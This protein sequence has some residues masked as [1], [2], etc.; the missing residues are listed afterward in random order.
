M[1]RS[2]M[3]ARIITALIGVIVTPIALGLISAGGIRVY[4]LFSAY[5]YADVD[6]FEFVGPIALNSSVS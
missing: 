1:Q 3:T 4:Q 2:S 6:L 5:G